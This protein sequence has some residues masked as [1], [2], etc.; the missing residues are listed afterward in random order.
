ML[1]DSIQTCQW[2]PYFLVVAWQ[3]SNGEKTASVEQLKLQLNRC[4]SPDIVLQKNNSTKSYLPAC[5]VTNRLRLDNN[6]PPRTHWSI[7]ATE[8]SHWCSVAVNPRGCPYSGNVEVHSMELHRSK[9]LHWLENVVTS[10][11]NCYLRALSCLQP[12]HCLRAFNPPRMLAA[13]RPSWC[14]VSY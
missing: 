1:P 14:V 11:P 8:A 7:C 10:S 4:F 12:L 3:K 6:Q 2:L 9:I 5:P 13:H